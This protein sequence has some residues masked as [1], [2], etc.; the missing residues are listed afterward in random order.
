MKVEMN[1]R[2]P[3]ESHV[4]PGA[5]KFS[6]LKDCPRLESNKGL[7]NYEKRAKLNDINAL[8]IFSGG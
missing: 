8:S 5:A 3:R 4:N 7:Q 1:R 2:E 6:E